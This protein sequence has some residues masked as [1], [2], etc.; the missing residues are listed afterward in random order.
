MLSI[1]GLS[2]GYG[3]MQVL[4]GVDIEVA[5]GEFV[6]LVGPNGCGK[7]TLLKAATGLLPWRS[8]GVS[9]GGS[10]VA[11][12][13]AKDLARKV[14]VVPQEPLLPAGFTALEVVL[15]GRTPHL[16]FFAQE[17]P[18]DYEKAREA[19]ARVD[20]TALAER[21]VDA[22]SGGERKK[23]VIARA[24]AQEAPLL[25]LDEPTSN[26][27]LPHQIATAELLQRLSRQE[28]A[29]VLAAIHDL[30]LASLFCD[31]LVLMA[32]GQVVAD[33][34][35]AAVLNPENLRRAYGF[36][37]AL[38]RLEDGRGPVVL[39]LTPDIADA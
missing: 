17:G 19:L 8:G 10:Q 12:V 22:L 20:A 25:L 34:A 36:E 33:G 27:D 23:V 1:R 38:L 32:S 6:G 30:T 29:A 35:P 4:R 39:P 28:G 24:L 3:E 5:A 16:G 15:M 9:I 21:P 14:A 11:G 31:R 2:T 7:T 26:L 37:P 18:A 13:S